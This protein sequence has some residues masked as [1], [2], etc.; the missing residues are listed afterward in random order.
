MRTDNTNF[1][2]IDQSLTNRC[3]TIDQFKEKY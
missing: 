3:N 2:Q 1:T